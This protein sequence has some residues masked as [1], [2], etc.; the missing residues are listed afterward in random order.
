MAL[1][2]ATHFIS[3]REPEELLTLGDGTEIRSR[4][5]CLESVGRNSPRLCCPCTHS[6]SFFV[7]CFPLPSWHNGREPASQC[8]RCGFDPWVR[9]DLLEE[10][11]VTHSNIF[12]W[13]IPWTK[14]PDGLQSMESES[15]RVTERTAQGKGVNREQR[16]CLAVC[17]F[18]DFMEGWG[19]TFLSEHVT[20]AFQCPAG[21]GAWWTVGGCRGGRGSRCRRSCTHHCLYAPCH[22]P[23]KAR[24]RVKGWLHSSPGSPCLRDDRQPCGWNLAPLECSCPQGLLRPKG[25]H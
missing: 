24:F 13:R 7:T 2:E 16:E 14:G 25:E 18:R 6:R 19:S 4:I 9:E 5:L 21:L 15:Q 12:A 10:E 17:G 3:V 8:R 1:L 22:R 20:S 11:M 23:W